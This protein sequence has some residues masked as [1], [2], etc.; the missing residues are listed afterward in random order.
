MECPITVPG[1]NCFAYRRVSG[2]AT[3]L[4]AKPSFWYVIQVNCFDTAGDY[5]SSI[6]VLTYICWM[7]PCRT[8][9]QQSSYFTV[10]L[11]SLPGIIIVIQYIS[12]ASSSSAR[13]PEAMR[14]FTAISALSLCFFFSPVLSQSVDLRTRFRE[15]NLDAFAEHLSANSPYIYELVAKR[16]DVTVWAPGNAAVKRFLDQFPNRKLARRD[17]RNSSDA[18]QFTVDPTPPTDFI[19]P[20]RKRQVDVNPTPGGFF[21]DSNFEKLFTLLNDPEYVN[22]GRG[23]QVARFTRNYASP[24]DGGVNSLAPIEIVSGLGD[25]RMTLRGP[26]KFENGIIY[27]V[28]EYVEP[29]RLS[30]SVVFN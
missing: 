9:P 22:L 17:V 6:Q 26:Y 25:T 23:D 29:S 8:C 16:N 28:T 10:P 11:H 18:G 24:T 13:T 19:L 4:E 5:S 21:S 7:L 12:Q 27:E 15:L 3:C 14:I 30:S 2:L 20:G 1:I